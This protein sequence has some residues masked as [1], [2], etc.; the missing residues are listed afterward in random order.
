MYFQK[1]R[2]PSNFRFVSGHAGDALQLG[3]A[4]PLQARVRDLGEDVFHVE[5]RD[6]A[7]WPLDPRLLRMH[8]DAFAGASTHSFGFDADG[9]LR[10]EDAQG[11]RV[12][13]GVP[14]ASVGVCGKAWL[15]QLARND[16]MRFHGQGEKVTGLEKTGRRTK[17]WNLDV[18]GDHPMPVIIDGQADPQYAAIPYLPIHCAP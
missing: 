9:T 2:H 5:F 14:R 18:W 7:R 4:A 16:D 13:A 6:D 8:D 17:F 15:V 12:L 11:A 3:D 1:I 10:L